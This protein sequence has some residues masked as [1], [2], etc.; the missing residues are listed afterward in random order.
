MKRLLLDL[1]TAAVLSIIVGVLFTLMPQTALLA[2]VWV[3]GIYAIVFGVMIVVL[4]FRL[5]AGAQRRPA[6]RR[7][8]S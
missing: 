8:P 4:G 5:R 2:Y 6:T 7:C 3:L 1:T